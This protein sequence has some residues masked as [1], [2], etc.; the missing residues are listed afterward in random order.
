MTPQR[1]ARGGKR[2]AVEDV[3]F[4]RAA[5]YA[6]GRKLAVVDRI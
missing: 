2:I 1:R 5:L 3:A 6:I 4:D